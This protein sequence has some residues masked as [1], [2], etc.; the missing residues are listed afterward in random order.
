[1]KKIIYSLIIVL[2]LCN[3]AVATPVGGMRLLDDNSELTGVWGWPRGVKVAGPA[4][5]KI[6]GV[7]STSDIDGSA[8]FHGILIDN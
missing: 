1:M 7:G 8:G 3:S 6:Q 5:I 4:I 2:Y